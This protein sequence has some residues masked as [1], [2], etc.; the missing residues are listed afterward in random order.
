MYLKKKNISFGQQIDTANFRL[1]YLQTQKMY[2]NIANYSFTSLVKNK[3]FKVIECMPGLQKNV[4]KQERHNQPLRLCDTSKSS[5]SWIFMNFL[6]QP[7]S[8]C[9]IRPTF[10]LK[11]VVH[12]ENNG[13]KQ[14]YEKWKS[15]K[16]GKEIKT[17]G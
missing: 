8:M 2:E 7:G 5:Q 12:N 3:C 10:L 15:E 17:Y 4:I 1:Q 6:L 13:G 14:N 16:F 11:H 9:P